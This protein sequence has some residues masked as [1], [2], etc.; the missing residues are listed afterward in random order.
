MAV[1]SAEMMNFKFLAEYVIDW[2]GIFDVVSI[3]KK[4]FFSLYGMLTS[5]KKKISSCINKKSTGRKCE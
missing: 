3:K 5:K 4:K 2:K 1:L